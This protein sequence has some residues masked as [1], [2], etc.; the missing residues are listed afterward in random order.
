MLRCSKCNARKLALCKGSFCKLRCTNCTDENGKEI[1]FSTP[2]E[3][4]IGSSK[5][6]ETITTAL[7]GEVSSSEVSNYLG[8]LGE[9]NIM[10]N[11]FECLQNEPCTSLQQIIPSLDEEFIDVENLSPDAYG[12]NVFQPAQS[13][14][15]TL[16]DITN[17]NSKSV[18]KIAIP[19]RGKRIVVPKKSTK[20][21]VPKK[22]SRIS[23]RSNHL[24][25][26]KC[27]AVG[28][29][30]PVASGID[31]SQIGPSTS[32]AL[33]DIT[34]NSSKA[35]KKIAVYK[36]TQ[37][38]K[39]NND[40]PEKPKIC[41]KPKT[42]SPLHLS[43]LEKALDVTYFLKTHKA[44]MEESSSE[45][46]DD[47]AN[48]QELLAI[49]DSD[50]ISPTEYFNFK[51]VSLERKWLAD[52]LQENTNHSPEDVQYR[53]IL[54]LHQYQKKVRF[55]KKNLN[56]YMY[57]GA[58]LVSSQDNYAA[59][60]K[61]PPPPL[62]KKKRRD[63]TSESPLYPPN[64]L[65]EITDEPCLDLNLENGMDFQNFDEDSSN[66]QSS[67]NSS[68][69]A[70]LMSPMGTPQKKKV[71]KF[72]DEEAKKKWEDM[73]TLKRKRVFS[74]LVKKEVGKQQRSKSNRHKE[75][76]IQCKRVAQQC[77]KFVRQKAV[78][79]ARIVKEQQW[80]M[81][82]LARENIAY[83]KRSRRLD[84]EVKKR[85]EKEAEEQRKI[86]HE[87]IEAKR[88]QRKL[89]FLITQTELYAHFMSKK[90]G[91]ASAEEQLRIL[92]QL[93][94]EK[95]PRLAAIDGYDSETMKEKAKKNAEEAFLSER[96]RTKHFDIE[97]NST[98]IENLDTGGEQPQP[99]IFRGKLKGYQ[100]RGMNWLA[101]LY[102]QGISGILADEMGL[103]K[104]VQSI[105]FLCH[106]AEKY[107]V[108]GPFLIISP[109]STLHNWQQEIAKFVPSFKVVPYWGNPNERKILRQFWDQKDIYTKEASFHI[110]IT[111]YQIVITDIK[112]FNRIKW[113]YMILDEAQ[114]IKSTSSMRWKTLLGFSCRNRLLLSGTP[115]Q[116][117][118]AE[119]WALLHFIMPTLFDSHEEFNEWFSKD[120]E[121]HAENKT[122]IDEKHLS[123]LHMILKPFMLRR[124][125][126]M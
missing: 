118:M 117:S 100:L 8:T 123:R 77:A 14:F 26:N 84:R 30:F 50:F 105:A 62:L 35:S 2:K 106:I 82:R 25:G 75:M 54:R 49:K 122:G 42:S 55:G 31:L 108:W 96:T 10:P 51:N 69:M 78:L 103:G 120:I 109:A 57:Y 93:D 70:L 36:R 1:L 92:N 79:S 85:M 59:K 18:T 107:A 17:I 12:L 124:I 28:N 47:E 15:T 52:I 7:A 113:Q 91:T 53:H 20:I 73:M 60:E 16:N 19:K 5:M 99:K 88:Q 87:L 101:N 4:S 126:R 102:S 3:P 121:S 48:K 104:T 114:A 65:E 24:P 71:K 86:D 43:K 66:V 98:F 89:N 97:A 22:G 74:N 63:D 23:V 45:S 39:G 11:Y 41:V 111:S 44:A 80:R 6:E 110:V 119:L 81:K 90:L 61:A 21:A 32:T 67:F 58:G 46:D 33:N 116:N 29:V 13:S 125:K 94:E 9:E 112:Y 34:I 56:D 83:W 76:L 37:I 115:I 40:L 95:N 27:I 68:N 64:I 72:K 38:I